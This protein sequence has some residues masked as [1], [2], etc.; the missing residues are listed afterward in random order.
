[1]K[2][3]RYTFLFPLAY[4]ARS[5]IGN[6]VAFIDGDVF[7]GRIAGGAS[8]VRFG[9]GEAGLIFGKSYPFE[10]SSHALR[11]DLI[12]VLA[13]SRQSHGKLMLGLPTTYINASGVD[14]LRLRKYKMWAPL[15]ALIR[16]SFRK[17]CS[18]FDAHI[19]YRKGELERLM[20]EYL[21]NRHVIVVANKDSL[22]AVLR[23]K[24]QMGCESLETIEVSRSG[25]YKTKE[26]LKAKIFSFLEGKHKE[27]VTIIFSCGPTAKILATDFFLEGY[28]S[29]DVGVGLEHLFG[30]RSI[31]SAI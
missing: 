19:F 22:D 23:S 20:G 6:K 5:M 16:L 18:V 11:T 29:Y 17:E 2:I 24:H 30:V 13:E 26:V 4:I 25:V 21:K 9:D 3:N 28:R 15:Q 7:W 1:M 12:S 14:L 8:F 27:S 31:E 10:R